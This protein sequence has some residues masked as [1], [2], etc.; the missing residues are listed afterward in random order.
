MV[1]VSPARPSLYHEVTGPDNRWQQRS[2]A[3]SILIAPLFLCFG[4]EFSHMATM[5]LWTLAGIA[6]ELSSTDLS[7]LFIRS[8][9]I[10]ALTA[11]QWCPGL[12]HTN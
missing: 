12:P 3:Y 9:C 5:S 11:T 1:C 8:T 4:H 6:G 10:L 7:F 2:Q